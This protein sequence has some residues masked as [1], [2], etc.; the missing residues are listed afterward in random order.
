MSQVKTGVIV[1]GKMN[2]T[3]VV[4]IRDT[5]KHPLYKKAVKRTKR[6]KAHNDLEALLHDKVKIQETK[7]YSK[8]VYF[9]I[10]EVIK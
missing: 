5:Y 4:E 8:K 2:K 3:V 6:I 1:A 10:V 9:K 7:P